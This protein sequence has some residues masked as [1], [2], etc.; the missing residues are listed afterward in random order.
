M[1]GYVYVYLKQNL[2]SYYKYHVIPEPSMGL[3]ILLYVIVLHKYYSNVERLSVINIFYISF[4]LTIYLRF[5]YG[6]RKGSTYLRLFIHNKF[7]LS[8][9]DV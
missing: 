3:L 5:I 2:A 6:T 8:R 7:I 9:K 4:F 1:F